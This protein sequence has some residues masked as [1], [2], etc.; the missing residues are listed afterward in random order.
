METIPRLRFFFSN[1]YLVLHETATK[2]LRDLAVKRLILTIE[3]KSVPKKT[4]MSLPETD[5]R[6]KGKGIPTKERKAA[7]DCN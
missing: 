7:T 3:E 6:I 5:D 1:D 4:M 2:P